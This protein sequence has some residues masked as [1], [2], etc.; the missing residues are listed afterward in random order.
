[1]IAESFRQWNTGVLDSYL[2]EITATVLDKIDERTDQPLV[3]VILDAAAQKGTGT[4][5]VQSALTLGVPVGAIAEAVFA[6]AVSSQPDQRA[7]VRA[8]FGDA[9]FSA[10]ADKAQLIT[11]VEQ[12]LYASKIVAYAQGFDLIRTASQEF[13][14]NIQPG[15]LA[16]IWRGGC[17]IRAAFLDRIKQA[18]ETDPQLWNLLV[19]D[20]FAADISGAEAQ[21]RTVIGQAVANGVPVPAF[22]ASLSY[23]DSLRRGRLPAALVQAQRDFFGAHTYRRVDAEGSFHIDWSGDGAEVSSG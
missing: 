16:T 15:D 20:T 14:W 13:G 3:D 1:E 5:T 23:F 10:A 21:W 18:Y 19:D 4:W 7:A 12:A 8:K 9:P 2:I 22:S 6:R 11:D 17:I